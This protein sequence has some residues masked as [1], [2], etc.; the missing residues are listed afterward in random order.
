MKQRCYHCKEE[1]D[2]VIVGKKFLCNSHKSLKQYVVKEK[3]GPKPL[4]RSP[5]K[6]K[7][8]KSMTKVSQ[9]EK[10]NI[11]NKHKAYKILEETKPHICTGCG[12]S[13]NLSHSHLVPVGQNKK[14]E[15]VVSNITYHCMDCHHT[16]E[17]DIEK[18]KG[19]LDYKENMHKISI[20]DPAYYKII[21][22]KCL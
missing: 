15:A 14:L 3:K 21:A 2:C 12:T 13:N 4:K 7:P 20:L 17:H 8:G 10:L 6:K 16:W 22:S 18:R 9:K 11:K 19:M 5:L 1:K